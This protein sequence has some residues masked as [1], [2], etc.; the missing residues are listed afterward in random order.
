M[1]PIIGA[2][3]LSAI[4]LCGRLSRLI[5]A[6][7]ASY[8]MSVDLMT[9]SRTMSHTLH[10]LLWALWLFALLDGADDGYSVDC[11]LCAHAGAGTATAVAAP[12]GRS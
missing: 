8:L 5:V 6:L 1:P 12:Y 10:L 2:S 4:G 7:C 3:L 11:W 9:S